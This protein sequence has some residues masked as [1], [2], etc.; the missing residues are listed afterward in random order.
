ML[1]II[2]CCRFEQKGRRVVFVVLSA[3]AP[4]ILQLRCTTAEGRNV[5][6]PTVFWHDG[7]WRCSRPLPEREQERPR[8]SERLSPRSAASPLPVVPP[9]PRRVL[10]RSRRFHLSLQPSLP[11]FLRSCQSP[12]LM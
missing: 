7:D 8:L 11:G 6:D 3:A 4:R 10:F 5:S 9:R 2:Y 1:D 12:G